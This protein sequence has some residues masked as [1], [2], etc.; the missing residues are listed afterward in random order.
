MNLLTRIGELL[1]EEAMPDFEIHFRDVLAEAIAADESNASSYAHR[2]GWPVTTVQNYLGNSV[3]RTSP[4]IDRLF[5][6]SRAGVMPLNLRLRLVLLLAD[7]H[8]LVAPLPAA[9]ADGQRVPD[10]AENLRMQMLDVDGALYHAKL[11]YERSLADGR[12]DQSEH[13]QLQTAAHGVIAF[14]QR[15]MG[16]LRPGRRARS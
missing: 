2:L 15:W 16:A 5:E 13:A 4:T 3:N 8:F 10:Q 1:D 12:I 7:G 6:T 9:N 14:V 11:L